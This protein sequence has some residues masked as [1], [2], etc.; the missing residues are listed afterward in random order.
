MSRLEAPSGLEGC[1]ALGVSVVKGV[2]T[3]LEKPSLAFV[4]WGQCADLWQETAWSHLGMFFCH[5][6]CWHSHLGIRWK[7][8][9]LDALGLEGKEIMGTG[10][11]GL[12]MSGSEPI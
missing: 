12:K 1:R 10:A 6:E 7:S 9:K 11:K 2:T 3:F 5:P 4:H 8:P